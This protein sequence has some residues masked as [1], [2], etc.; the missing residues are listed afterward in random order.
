MSERKSLE[1]IVLGTRP[2][3]IKLA[4][5]IRAFQHTDHFRTGVVLTCKNSEME[6]PGT[7]LFGLRANTIFDPFHEKT[8]RRRICQLALL[9]F[10]STE[11][12]AGT[13]KLICTASEKI[14]AKCCILLSSSASYVPVARGH[15]LFDDGQASGR[16]VAKARTYF[17]SKAGS[18]H[19]KKDLTPRSTDQ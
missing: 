7:E 8:N 10:A 13:A 19:L 18:K 14:V 9:H 12:Q 4:P 3:A 17:L 16:I 6:I 15:N 5:M 2:K 1:S 11:V